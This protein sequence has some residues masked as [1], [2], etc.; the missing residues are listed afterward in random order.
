MTRAARLLS[1]W[2]LA[3]ATATHADPLDTCRIERL[4][5][6]EAACLQHVADTL[7]QAL[8]N[9]IESAATRIQ[10]ATGPELQDFETE[11]RRTQADWRLK[12]E[13]TC[14]EIGP[15]LDPEVQDCR[16]SAVLDREAEID[17]VFAETIDPLVGVLPG[18]EYVPDE[19]EVFVPLPNP[20]AGPFAP[21]GVPVI[22]PVPRP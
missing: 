4:A 22:V 1:L 15:A 6:A 7:L 19:I 5:Q 13:R 10:L 11:L 14:S 8:T 3:F 21:T 17:A 2:A 9:R 18:S 16:L 20:P 12:M